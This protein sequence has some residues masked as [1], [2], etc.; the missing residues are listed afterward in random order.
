MRAKME[1]KGGPW[2][3]QVLKQCYLGSRGSVE[4]RK[5]GTKPKLHMKTH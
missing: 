5:E 2:A 1:F 4:A 3:P